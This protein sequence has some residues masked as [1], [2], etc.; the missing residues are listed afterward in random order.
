MSSD[1]IA[2]ELETREVL[3]KGLNGLRKQGLVPAVIHDHGKPSLHVQGDFIKLTKIY[4]KAGKHHPV[5]L[6]I[7]NA[8]HLALIKDVDFE[9]TKRLI[10]HVVFQAVK[11]DEK[12]EA[13]IPIS[14]EE[15]EI[16]AEKASLMVLKQL[17]H[18]EVEALPR[19]LPDEIKVDPSTLAEVGDRLTVADLKVPEGVTILAEP[20]T[21]IAVV[22]MPRDQIAEA[23]A[24]AEALAEDAGTEEVEA[25]HGEDTP[26]DTQ[27]EETRPGGK[28]QK[29]PKPNEEQS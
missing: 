23:D 9:P 21:Q 25:E 1:N 28:L 16:P 26:Q 24:A 5:E 3:H 4:S 15:V 8:Q 13:E 27:A 29:E 11:R 10:R 22:E 14:F 19:N 2:V 17:D 20:E 18:V 6:K 12:V 7:G